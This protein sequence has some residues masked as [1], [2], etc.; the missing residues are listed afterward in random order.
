LDELYKSEKLKQDKEEIKKK[1]E[2]LNAKKG[3]SI[4][5]RSLKNRSQEDT[6][7]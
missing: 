7:M 4:K 5:T 1:S 6:I 3:V 2:P